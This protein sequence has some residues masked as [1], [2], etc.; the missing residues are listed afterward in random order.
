MGLRLRLKSSVDIS[1]FSAQN[2]VILTALKKYGAIV[3]DNGLSWFLSG[4]YDSRWDSNALANLR[5]IRG[6]DFE[7]VDTGG[8]IQPGN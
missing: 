2:Q 4:T 3:T 1:T 7:V 8:T 6:S 5:N